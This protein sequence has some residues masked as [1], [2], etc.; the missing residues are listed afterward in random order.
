MTELDRIFELKKEMG[1]DLIILAHHYQS[2]DIVKAADFTG[3]SLKLAQYAQQ[4]KRARYIVFCGVYFMSETADILTEDD[5]IIL[6]PSIIAGCPMADMADME[7][8]ER[9]WDIITAE[10]GCD[11][12]PITYVN[13][14][15][16][17]K[18]FCGRKGGTTVT[19]GNAAKVVKWGLDQNKVILFLP[20][21]N[22][23]RN[24]AYDLGIPL[25]NMAEYDPKTE[26][27]EYSCDKKDVKIV[28]WK[29]YCHVH[30]KITVKHIE[31]ARKAHPNAKVIVHPEC[32]FEIAQAADG[33][34]S[35]EYIINQV[36]NGEKGSKWIIGT[37]HNL[38]KR[39]KDS[40]EDKEVY[41]LDTSSVCTNMNR[42]TVQN[43]LETL[44]DIKKGNFEKRVT[45][46]KSIAADAVK[47]LETMLSLV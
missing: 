21:Q 30:H 5:Q 20:D 43:L 47:S 38:V 8:A 29:G 10:L 24:T 11:I 13:S 3:D 37:E 35:T 22:L 7:Q 17:V 44:E 16:E 2:D 27:L 18:A 23:G 12:V 19:S 4:N 25:D 26:T 9:A 40:F 42:T 28:L 14:K 46:D 41:I 31:A 45:V 6:Q 1:D 36:R 39:L 32:Q 34:G 15:A 33:K